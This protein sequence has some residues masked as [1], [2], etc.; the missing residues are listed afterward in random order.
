MGEKRM[1]GRDK[2]KKNKKDTLEAELTCI[3]P[4]AWTA[5][6]SSSNATPQC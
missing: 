3:F 2:K 6:Q 5:Q 1:G 4:V